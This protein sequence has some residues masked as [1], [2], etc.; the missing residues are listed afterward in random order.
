[1]KINRQ[2]KSGGIM[3]TLIETLNEQ[4]TEGKWI[5]L[6]REPTIIDSQNREHSLDGRYVEIED[7]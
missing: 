4:E 2:R 5:R 3:D 1:M 7:K 6:H